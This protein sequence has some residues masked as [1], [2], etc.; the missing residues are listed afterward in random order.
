MTADAMRRRPVEPPKID[1]PRAEI[2]PR[3]ELM[4]VRPSE[5]RIDPAYQRLILARGRALIARMVAGWDWELCDP[6]K[7]AEL[8]EGLWEV[9]DGQH[10]VAAALA[11]GGIY[12]LP[13]FVSRLED[14][15]ARARVFVALNEGRT[16]VT[17]AAR[18][19]AAVA[20]GEAEAVSIAGACVA[21]GATPMAGTRAGGWRVGDTTAIAAL[22][23][24][25]RAAG[26]DGLKRA[27]AACVAAGLAP[28]PSDRLSALAALLG[29]IVETPPDPAAL[30]PL[31][32]DDWA[33]IADVAD[34]AAA[35]TGQSRARARAVELHRRLT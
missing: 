32:G 1:G 11:H 13:A 21:A 16:A 8:P 22:Y 7:V 28:I 26:A 25:L 6:I 33:Q 4:W 19:K 12:Q 9:I 24:L 5:C 23:R 20:A 14:R 10:R 35:E 15:A 30:A 29:E 3:P 27:L 17:P 31:L 18:F 2:G 34:L